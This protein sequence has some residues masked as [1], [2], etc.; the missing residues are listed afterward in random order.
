[1]RTLIQ[2]LLTLTIVLGLL[3]CDDNTSSMGIVPE[4]DN[5]S[6]NTGS[7]QVSSRSVLM[8]AVL[9][10]STTSYLG[11]VTDPETNTD[12]SADFIAQFFSFENFSL[13]QRQQM[14]GKA[15]S[16][17]T[18]D[19]PGTIQCDSIEVRLYFNSYYG[20]G[21]NPIKIQAYELS[22]TNIPSEDDTY[23]TNQD[24]GLFV[25]D[26]STPVA[27]KVIT[28]KDYTASST[29]D[30]IR[31]R[32][33]NELGTRILK[34]YYAQPAHFQKSYQFIHNVF[35][36]LF[37]QVSSGRGTMLNVFVGVVN[38]FFHYTDQETQKVTQGMVRFSA[39]PEVIQSTR[40]R[41]TN[42]DNLVSQAGY[43]YL[44]TPA[45]I[46]TELT[47]P[48]DEVFGGQHAND[49]INLA[50]LTLT[51]Y[52]NQQNSTSLGTPSNLLMVRKKD[53]ETFFAKKQVSDNRTSFTTSYSSSYN[54]YTFNNIGR[55]LSYCKNEKK[56]DAQKAG[57]SEEAWTQQNPDWNKVL[58]IPVTT[59]SNTS[60]TQVSVSHDLG[61]NS[62][63]LVGGTTPINMQVVYSTF[64]K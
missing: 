39:T 62:I 28:A 16:T 40:F 7:F 18:Q 22:S 29:S 45:G 49:S 26:L 14:L 41:T 17:D 25:Q 8:D 33:S 11:I 27:S 38:L 35:P 48:V 32:L 30:N 9:A 43:T 15:N 21:N 46:A 31:L 51:R 56:A 5:I 6:S 50:S 12:I 63:R 19:T 34:H 42:L 2:S 54:T 20:E 37:F 44:K 36:G 4:A 47:L 60:G 59:S 57:L 52:N 13:P 53:Y 24:L 61:L 55:L 64:R 10:N 1:M 58:L 3:G 23:L